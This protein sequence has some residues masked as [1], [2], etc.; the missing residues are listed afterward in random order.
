MTL[1][2]T[3]RQLEYLTAVGETGSIA[4]A[5]ARVNVSPPSVSA[6]I[7]QLEEELGAQLFI[8][9]HA[10]GLSLTPSGR[11]IFNEAR[12]I[13]YDAGRL[14]VI[15]RETR[16][17]VGGPIAVGFLASVAPVIAARVRRGFEAL[18]P[19]AQVTMRV[20]HQA[21]LLRLLNRAEI[22]LAVTYDLELPPDCDFAAVAELPPLVAL[23]AG[24]RLAEK[25]EIALRDLAGEAM[26]LLDLPL[27]REYMLAPFQA[28]GMR[29][30]IAERSPDLGVV[31]SLVANGYGFALLN[32]RTAALEALDGEKLAFVPLSGGPRPLTLGVL[33]K[34]TPHQTRAHG[35][36]QTYLREL[37]ETRRLPGLR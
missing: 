10:Q 26:V 24:H 31:R 18:Y 5:A 32:L 13:V 14:P 1:R 34:A 19:D 30:R 9:R 16:E 12:R 37:A 21:D 22:D 11:R 25:P 17:T 27:S 36:F 2:F 15:A 8:R 35:A 6:A 33:S 3:L 4:A 23:A 28:A 7:S 20:A 29:P